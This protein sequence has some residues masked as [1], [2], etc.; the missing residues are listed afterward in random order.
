MDNVERLVEENQKLM[1]KLLNKMYLEKDDEALSIAF[2]A[3]F[4]AAK[5]FEPDRGNKFSTVAYIYIYNALGN[6]IKHLKHLQRN[7]PLSYSTTLVTYSTGDEK[8]MLQCI[9]SS[10]TAD[11]NTMQEELG[12]QIAAALARTKEY[13]KTDL[14]RSIFDMWY[15]SEFQAQYQD[16]AKELK[17]SSAQVSHTI[18]VIRKNFKYELKGYYYD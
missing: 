10:E 15:A 13:L 4:K 8:T 2:E 18:A 7:Q 6:Y 5:D 3:L 16:I 9:A 17:C 1:W 14:Q 11:K 12:E